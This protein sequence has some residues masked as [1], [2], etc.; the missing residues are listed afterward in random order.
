[1]E[2]TS[3]NNDKVKYWMKLQDKKFRD[4]EGLF[5]V[6]GDHLVN[7]AIKNGLAKE[8]ITLNDFTNSITT[9]KVTEE[10][11]KKISK[12]K[13]ISS[14][15]AVCF[16]LKEK[17]I[18]NKVICLDNI[19]DPG[20]LGTIIRSAVAFN[21]DTIILNDKSVDL[22]NDKVIRSSEG[23][24]FNV[25]VIRTNLSETLKTLKE[26][27][28][29]VIGTSVKN[30]NLLKNVEATDKYAII[31]GNEGNGTSKEIDDLCDD[32]IYI[33][34]NESCESLNVAVASSIIMYELNR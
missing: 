27:G 9:Y 29:K 31:L 1:M 22:Y 19:Q 17:Q 13:S 5:I 34:M 32:F 16:K 12:Q 6:E 15:A 11:M 26:N 24:I 3:L 7:E 30:N 33:T 18:G 8:I 14:I 25:N 21:I 23:M 10:I 20:N 4:E 28:Y 2:I